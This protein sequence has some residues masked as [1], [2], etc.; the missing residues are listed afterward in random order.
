MLVAKYEYLGRAGGSPIF[1]VT[2][3]D[4][5]T[6]KTGPL[7]TLEHMLPKAMYARMQ[8]IAQQDIQ[9]SVERKDVTS[10]CNDYSGGF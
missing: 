9:V 8:R 4:Y 6:V 1:K 3:A 5:R 7:H 10:F 2:Y